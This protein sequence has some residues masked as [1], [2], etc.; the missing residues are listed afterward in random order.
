VNSLTGAG[1]RAGFD[2]FPLAAPTEQL[3][4]EVAAGCDRLG[5]EHTAVWRFSGYGA[6]LDIP[7]PR[8][9]PVRLV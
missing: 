4:I 9:I 2:V 5:I 1:R 8:G 6:G 3:L 7:D